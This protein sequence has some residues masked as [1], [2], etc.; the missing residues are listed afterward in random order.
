MPE[1]P[2]PLAP[3]NYRDD[4]PRY[5]ALIQ[6][7]RVGTATIVGPAGGTQVLYV[8]ETEQLRTDT[9]QARD[10]E[11]CLVLDTNGFGLAQGYYLGRLAGSY[12]SLPVYETAQGSAATIFLN[13]TLAQ[14]TEIINNL[15]VTQ[16]ENL[17]NLNPCQMQVL[18][19]TPS[20]LPSVTPGVAVV[21]SSLTSANITY[22]QL[23]TTNLSMQQ[24]AIL[25]GILNTSQMT[26]IFDN[27]SIQQISVLTTVFN[28]VQILQILEVI[29]VVQLGLIINSLTVNQLMILLQNV[30]LS[31]LNIFLTIPTAYWT[32][33]L[34]LTSIQIYQI[35]E[36]LSLLSLTQI[37]YLFSNLT[38]V[39]IYSFSIYCCYPVFYW[40]I[41]GLTPAELIDLLDKKPIAEPLGLIHGGIVGPAPGA[42]TALSGS[43]ASGE[44]TW[45][46]TKPASGQT[47]DT[48]WLQLATD[49][50]FTSNVQNFT[51][52]TGTSYT[53]TGLTNGTTY[54]ARVS[55]VYNGAAGSWSS[56]ANATPSA[57]A[58]IAFVQKLP[59]IATGTGVTTLQSSAFAGSVTSG[60]TVVVTVTY[61]GTGSVSSVTDT[62]GNTYSRGDFST[63]DANGDHAEIWYS[64]LSTGGASNKVTVNVNASGLLSF[65]AAEFSGLTPTV[66]VTGTAVGSSTSPAPG[67]YTTTTANEL[68]V[69]VVASSGATSFTAPASFTDL[70]ST[71]SGCAGESCYE[72]VS[73]IQT[74]INPAWT[75]SP[76]AAWSTVVVTF[77]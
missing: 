6:L 50:A 21:G 39:Q 40:L 19:D 76:S 67:S 51:G 37:N 18:L 11:P 13:L 42:P 56:S 34:T 72:I 58:S 35:L 70:G 32:N 5:P 43:A 52:I 73:T 69:Q 47:P 7:V 27:L 59:G 53:T 45:S 12:Q 74:A 62:L 38:V 29:S 22:L 54:Y 30:N 60:N 14:I 61:K 57:P 64:S 9:L 31:Q 15:T 20:S 28:S 1:R 46:Y 65:N 24:I 2:S 71:T 10:R 33:I 26:V 77:K 4:L 41:T 48:Y 17:Y 16:I 36:M 75:I 8:G 23:L 44:I 55:G 68:L 49:S 25:V 3:P 63:G 66:D